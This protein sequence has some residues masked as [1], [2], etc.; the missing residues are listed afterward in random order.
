MNM[1]AIPPY[2]LLV[3]FGAFLLFF[4]FFAFANI[5]SIAKYGG[6]TTAGFIAVFIFISAS[7]I[8]LFLIWRAL[9]ALDWQ[10]PMPI[11]RQTINF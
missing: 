6:G 3:I 1:L 5:F 9:P 4:L 11:L 10:T 8:V 7:A 2:I